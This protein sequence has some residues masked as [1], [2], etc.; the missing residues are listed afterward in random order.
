MPST[1]DHTAFPF[2][3]DR[4]IL[5][6]ELDALLVLRATC[7]QLRDY[8]TT[9]VFSHVR[10]CDNGQL[11]GSGPKIFSIFP[12][13]DTASSPRYYLDLET[14]LPLIAHPVK[15][16]DIDDSGMAYPT[17]GDDHL[18]LAVMSRFTNVTTLRRTSWPSVELVCHAPFGA[19]VHTVVDDINT[20][21]NFIRV[22][23]RIPC[24]P[25]SKR[26]IIHLRWDQDSNQHYKFDVG[27]DKVPELEE[28]V[29]VL[30]PYSSGAQESSEAKI[31][32]EVW[33]IL[34]SLRPLAAHGRSIIVVGLE[35]VRRDQIDG[36][37]SA[38]EVIDPIPDPFVFHLSLAWLSESDGIEKLNRMLECVT[39]LSLTEW[40]DTLPDADKTL[41]GWPPMF[42]SYRNEVRGPLQWDVQG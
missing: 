2:I 33:S 23:Y 19:P 24:I 4:I 32:E 42:S 25:G 21:D 30:W 35:A 39:R 17:G 26:H 8:I 15:V 5:H 12:L 34:H 11:F 37:Y 28:F 1:I 9:L 20:Q 7:Q 31:S 41:L 27:I 29:I 6:A 38:R 13:W 18:P 22:G 14:R 36:F 16:L 10:L 40:H 3:I